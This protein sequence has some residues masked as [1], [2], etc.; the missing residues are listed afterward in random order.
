[1]CRPVVLAPVRCAESGHVDAAR[2]R[3]ENQSADLLRVPEREADRDHSAHGLSDEIALLVQLDG[4]ELDEIFP[5]PN[6]AIVRLIAGSGPAEKRLLP[7][8]RQAVRDR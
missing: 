2:G 8:I 7:L 4:S 6:G 5:P 1:M 3:D